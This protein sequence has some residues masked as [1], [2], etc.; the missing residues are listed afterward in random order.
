MRQIQPTPPYASVSVN[1]PVEGAFTYEVP[2]N[3]RDSIFLGTRLAV[4]FGKRTVTGYVV[5]FEKKPDIKNIKPI[6][7]V[8]DELPLF[9]EKKLKF[10]QWMSSYYLAPLGEVLSLTHPAALKVKT[11]RRLRLT[12][13]GK[14]ALEG[15]A[16]DGRTLEILKAVREGVAPSSLR[17][18]FGGALDGVKESG[19]I[20]EGA[21]L[22]G[23]KKGR[24][25][26]LEIS[27]RP[28][29]HAPNRDQEEAIKAITAGGGFSPFLLYGVTGS[30]KTLVYLKAIEHALTL[31]RK[32]LYLMPETALTEVPAQY[33]SQRFPSR[34]AVMHSALT[35]RERES[36]WRRILKGDADIVVGARSALFSPLRDIGIIIVDEE[37][38]Q[39]Y[40]SETGV[41]YNARDCALMLG[42]ILDIPVVLGSATPSVETFHNAMKSKGTIA[43]LYLR[44]RP[45]LTDMPAVEVLDMKG[46]KGGALSERLVSLTKETLDRGEQ[47]LLFLNRR[48]FSNFVLCRDCGHAIR[49]LNCSVTLTL[50]KGEGILKCHYCDLRI[51]IPMEC[52]SC[53]S[54]NI[55]SP[56][57]GTEKIEQEARDIFPSVKVVRLDRDT[58]RRRNSAKRIIEDVESKKAGVLVGTQMAVKGHDFPGITLVGVVSADTALNIPDFRSSERTFQ[59]LLQASGRA[60][61]RGAPSTVVVQTLNPEHYCFASALNH[62][63][64]GFFK[65]EIKIR[66]EAEYPPFMRL[67]LLRVEGVDRGRVLRA[68]RLLVDSLKKPCAEET[69]ILGPA[70][71]LVERVKGRLRMQIL[72][73]CRDAKKLNS[74]LHSVKKEF[75]RK[76]PPGVTLVM[77]VDPVTTV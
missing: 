61:R 60:G 27:P 12:D 63:Y 34:V 65:E 59:L 5:G 11:L 70:P 40:K 37:H 9:D 76:K 46:S 6:T 16:G 32:A 19:L 31:G 45:K 75:T 7:E 50:H 53:G 57:A 49:C 58:A 22:K 67:A 36:Q 1:L 52:P 28:L 18:R 21:V 4:P 25:K 20:T 35:G 56:G 2:E 73:K 55:V 71:A 38:D 26:P 77:D 39:S 66:K 64:E 8:L 29:P 17:R 62:D 48:G 42:K 69:R 13:K 30:G 3:L 54:V 68:V 44:S 41:R 10:F 43:P 74:I 14:A 24:T 33:L 47:A 72:L 15:G 51:P 23:L